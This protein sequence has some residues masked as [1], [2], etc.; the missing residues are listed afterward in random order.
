MAKS[1]ALDAMVPTG[2]DPIP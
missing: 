2:L 1:I